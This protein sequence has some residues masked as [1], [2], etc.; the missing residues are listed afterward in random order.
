MNK[1]SYEMMFHFPTK[2][3]NRTMV[4]CLYTGSTKVDRLAEKQVI[5]MFAI[6]NVQN[7]H[8]SIMCYITAMNLSVHFILLIAYLILNVNT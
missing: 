4:G 1:K 2:V 7:N 6:T 3:G 5:G 8:F